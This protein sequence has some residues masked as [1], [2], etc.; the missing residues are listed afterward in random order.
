MADFRSSTTESAFRFLPGALRLLRDRRGLTQRELAE[1]A[2]C[3]LKQISAYETGRQR[4]RIETLERLL[5]VLG[6]D[7][8][9][10]A[11][12]MSGLAAIE[13]SG[14]S[15]AGMRPGRVRYAVAAADRLAGG[16]EAALSIRTL[17]DI[18]QRLPQLQGLAD[19]LLLGI[20]ADALEERAKAMARGLRAGVPA[21]T[22]DEPD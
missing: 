2:A 22:G 5:E 10:L 19:E 13:R 3:T 8:A 14:E 6:S 7:A 16:G 17:R 15:T 1:R 21:K 11:R 18:G 4:P 12:A 20:L 9:D